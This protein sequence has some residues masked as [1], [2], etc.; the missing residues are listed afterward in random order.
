MYRLKNK[1]WFSVSVFA[2]S[3]AIIL[4]AGFLFGTPAKH[5]SAQATCSV[6]GAKFDPSSDGG[7]QGAT[8]AQYYSS[9][10][11]PD[12]TI[13]ISTSNCSGKTIYVTL[14]EEN[15]KQQLF[16]VLGGENYVSSLHNKAL[17]VPASGTLVIQMQT[18]EEGCVTMGAAQH[19]THAWYDCD[20][21]LYAGT[22]QYSYHST[23]LS[24][25]SIYSSYSHTYGQMKYNCDTGSIS[26]VL[27]GTI[28]VYGEFFGCTNKWQYI[29]DNQSPPQPNPVNPTPDP[30]AP[31]NG[32]TGQC[33]TV[34]NGFAQALGNKF[35]SISAADSLG[36]WLNAIIAFIIGI[37]TILAVAMIM[38]QGFK[39]MTAKQEGNVSG[40]G[41]ASSNIWKIILG[42]LLLLCIYT[43]LKTIN[44]DL[45]NLTPTIQQVSIVQ[46]ADN[47]S[48]GDQVSTQ[49]SNVPDR[50][51]GFVMKGTFANP[52]VNSATTNFPQAVQALKGGA[53]IT[54]IA[55]VTAGGSATTG[56][57]SFTLSTGLVA[58]S[59][60][61]TGYKG[62]AES[63]QGVSGD[64]KTPKGSYTIGTTLYVAKSQDNGVISHGYNY[65][66]AFLLINI[67]DQNG[68]IRGI[69]IHG[70]ADD[71]LGTTN[72]C[73][74]MYNDELVLIAPYVTSG[75]P[76]T[77]S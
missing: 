50:G 53:T 64:N 42:L 14:A 41:S 73:I 45:L 26:S 20:Y 46:T 10:N 28:P 76:I 40:I 16:A 24:G 29:S 18:G 61:R 63:G 4:G 22:N 49:P 51:E 35:N 55:V 7:T 62:V 19:A 48:P 34:F 3:L 44:P 17:V 65:G 54:K 33:Y 23:T 32:C 25:G 12:A 68:T 70:K 15:A 66:A 74:R 67:P 38:V 75:I 11:P 1:T 69:G 60:I 71:S 77:I 31:T 59:P 43:L 2:L 47:T 30:N 56:T 52:V 5:A 27:A 37:G 57:I 6:T 36:G 9:T 21:Y 39:Y 72:G 13:T 8:G 58:T